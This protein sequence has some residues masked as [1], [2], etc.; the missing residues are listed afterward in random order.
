[1]KEGEG[2]PGGHHGWT[3]RSS[4]R[5]LGEVQLTESARGGSS[6]GVQSIARFC[7]RSNVVLRNVGVGRLRRRSL[8]GGDIV[9]PVDTYRNMGCS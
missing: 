7:T 9:L 3:F 1:M 8:R 2:N 6:L 4:R 5:V